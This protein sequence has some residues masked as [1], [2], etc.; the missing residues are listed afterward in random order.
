MVVGGN[1][2][3][4]P[5]QLWMD[6]VSANTRVRIRSAE[7]DNGFGGSYLT[8]V[9]LVQDLLGARM[10]VVRLDLNEDRDLPRRGKES[11]ASDVKVAE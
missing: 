11:S 7:R 10:N 5:K 4:P 3:V 2:F 1:R 6:L 9:N 8:Y